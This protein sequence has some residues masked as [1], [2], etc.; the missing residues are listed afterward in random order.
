M[1]VGIPENQAW[2]CHKEVRN[3]VPGRPE[4]TEAAGL[5][6]WTGSQKQCMSFAAE[7]GNAVAHEPW[8]CTTTVRN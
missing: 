1:E 2:G 4:S 5:A 3:Y 7:L 8:C 6:V